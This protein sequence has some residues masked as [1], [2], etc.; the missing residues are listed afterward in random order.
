MET[1]IVMDNSA[2][3]LLFEKNVPHI[4]EK[5]FLSIDY[6]SFL[7]CLKVSKRWTQLLT[8]ESFKRIGSIMLLHAVKGKSLDGV[9]LLLQ[10]GA[11]PNKADVCG[12]TV[13]HKAVRNDYTFAFDSC[14]NVVKLL[15]DGGADP[16]VQTRWGS[17]PLHYAKINGN[18]NM[19]RMLLRYMSRKAELN[20]H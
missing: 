13:L 2:F 17:T 10:L 7:S 15:L 20:K 3:D 6:R 8:S 9:Q 11:N 1:A 12:W 16:N 18:K 14:D 4:L 5:I 19:V